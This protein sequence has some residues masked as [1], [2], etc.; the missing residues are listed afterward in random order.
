VA[1]ELDIVDSRGVKVVFCRGKMVVGP[2]VEYFKSKV[3]DL[4]PGSPSIVLEFKHLDHID[5]QGV[6]MIVNL[7]NKAQE[8]GGDVRL[9]SVANHHVYQVLEITKM[10]TVFQIFDDERQAVLSFTEA[11]AS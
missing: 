2:D 5:S 11:R 8:I 7:R 9:A 3:G 10:T 1:L 4:L 6:G